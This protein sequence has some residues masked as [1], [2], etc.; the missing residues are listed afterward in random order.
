LYFK[1]HVYIVH[2]GSVGLLQTNS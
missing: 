1:D 2:S